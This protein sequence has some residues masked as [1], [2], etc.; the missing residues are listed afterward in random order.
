MVLFKY[1]NFREFE[2]LKKEK[3]Y[4]NTSIIMS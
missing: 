4:L 1:T 3:K 2:K